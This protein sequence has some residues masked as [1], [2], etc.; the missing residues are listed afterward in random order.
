MSV[1]GLNAPE[2]TEPVGDVDHPESVYPGLDI[3]V[4]P[5]S[6]TPLTP[7]VYVAGAPVGEPLAPLVL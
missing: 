3:P 5:G 2:I 7:V 4:S 6:A 1:V